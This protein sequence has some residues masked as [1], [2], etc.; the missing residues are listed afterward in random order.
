MAG[1]RV[2]YIID[3]V[4]QDKQLRQQMAKINWEELI[5]SKGKGVSDAF[6]KGTADAANQLKNTFSG[7]NIDW[8]QI[9]GAKDLGRLEQQMAKVL[10][11][12]KNQIKAFAAM[13]DVSGIQRTVEYVSALGS[14]LKGLG[15]NFDAAQ[16]TRGMTS[17]MRVLGPLSGKIDELANE[18]KK[19]EAAFDILFNKTS[20]GMNNMVKSSEKIT[21]VMSKIEASTKKTGGAQA[22]LDKLVKRFGE[23]QNVKLPDLSSFTFSQLETEMEK[24][25]AKW[26]QLESKFAGKKRSAEYLF[27][28]GQLLM[29]EK[30]ISQAYAS[31]SGAS[32]ASAADIQDIEKQIQRIYSVVE[33]EIQKLQNQLSSDTFAQSLAKQLS[34][35]QVKLSLPDTAR[36]ELRSQINTFINELNESGI[37][38]A[39][40]KIDY[41]LTNSDVKSGIAN[42]VDV[43][44]FEQMLQSEID[45]IDTK[46]AELKEKQSQ[47]EEV[48]NL[49]PKNTTAKSKYNMATAQLEELTKQKQANEYSL[50]NIH[51]EGVQRALT[52]SLNDFKAINKVLSSQQ[53]SMLAETIAWRQKMID[54]M[55]FGKGDI[56]F[57]FGIG[58][59]DS[60]AESLLDELNAFFANNVIDINI[61]KEKLRKDIVSAFGEGGVALGGGGVG[62]AA[63]DYQSLVSAIATGLQAALTGD[64]TPVTG[65]QKGDSGVKQTPVVPVKK[66]MYLDP[67]DPYNAYMG[68]AFI[69]IAKYAQG[70]GKPATALSSF[71]DRKGLDPE[72]LKSIADSG[73]I[74]NALDG[75]ATV[76]EKGGA[77]LDDEFKSLVGSVGRNKALSTFSTDLSELLYTL[78]IS[79]K[80]VSQDEISRQSIDVFKDFANKQQLVSGLSNIRNLKP[81]NL[82]SLKSEDIGNWASIAQ[83]IS[84]EALKSGNAVGGE[85][86]KNIVN[87]LNTLKTARENAGNLDD[88]SKQQQLSNAVTQFKSSIEQVYNDLITYITTFRMHAYVKGK[89]PIAVAGGASGRSLSRVLNALGGD[90]S[91][92]EDVTLQQYPNTAALGVMGRRDEQRLMRQSGENTL[93]RPGPDRM[94]I[95]NKDVTVRDFVLKENTSTKWQDP[96]EASQAASRRARAAADMLEDAEKRATSLAN[97]EAELEQQIAAKRQQK[98]TAESEIAKNQKQISR[99]IGEDSR[100]I[101]GAQTRLKNSEA[102]V[103]ST[104]QALTLARNELEKAQMEKEE[105]DKLYAQIQKNAARGTYKQYEDADAQVAKYEAWGKNPLKYRKDMIGEVKTYTDKNGVVHQSLQGGIYDDDYR[106]AMYYK[107]QAEQQVG[108]TE[109]LLAEA[110]HKVTN[111]QKSIEKFG[112]TPE[113]RQSL[114]RAMAD[115][116]ELQNRLVIYKNEVEKNQ[117]IINDI[118]RK[119]KGTDAQDKKDFAADAKRKINGYSDENGDYVP[120][121]LQN[122]LQYRR[123]LGANPET[124]AQSRLEQANVMLETAQTQADK[125]QQAYDTALKKQNELVKSDEYI[126]KAVKVNAL[127]NKNELLSQE[128][129]DLN[130][131]IQKD[132]AAKAQTTEAMQTSAAK[133]RLSATEGLEAS[134]NEL[135]SKQAVLEK[136][137]LDSK[138]KAES[139]DNFV[140]QKMKQRNHQIPKNNIGHTKKEMK[141]IDDYYSYQSRGEYL[142]S[143]VTDSFKSGN[144]VPSN[145]TDSMKQAVKVLTDGRSIL[146]SLSEFS[147]EADVQAEV[148]SRLEKN[149]AGRSKISSLIAEYYNRILNDGQVGATEWLNTQMSTASQK[150]KTLSDADVNKASELKP[151][152]DKL[153][154]GLRQSYKDNVN[155]WMTSLQQKIATLNTEGLSEKDSL[156]ATKE[157]EGL[158]DLI[159]KAV[160]DYNKRYISKFNT[161]IQHEQDNIEGLQKELNA[162]IKK[163]DLVEQARIEEKI[164]NAQEIIS[165][166]EKRKSELALLTPEQ[167]GLMSTRSKY[168]Y[169][170]RLNA[171]TNQKERELR[172]TLSDTQS[173][174]SERSM[175]LK[176]R[177]AEILKALQ[178]PSTSKSST[179]KLQ[180]ELQGINVE[181]AKYQQ[182]SQTLSVHNIFADDVAFVDEYKAKL[183]E[184]IALEQQ[185]DI[186]RSTGAPS[187]DLESRYAEINSKQATLD[188]SVYDKLQAKQRNLL[189]DISTFAKEGKSTSMLEQSL[190]NV[191]TLLAKYELRKRR[192]EQSSISQG[193]ESLFGTSEYV[194]KIYNEKIKETI[195][196]EQELALVR[197]KSKDVTKDQAVKDATSALNAH[198]N[199]AKKAIQRAM[200]DQADIDARGSARVQ[201]LEYL[202]E[203]EQA[204]HDA[205]KKKY[206]L[207]GRI[208]RKEG[209][210]EDVAY[211]D[212]YQNTYLYRQHLNAKK[213]QMIDEYRY[214]DQYAADKDSGMAK[215]EAEMRAYLS[216]T[217]GPEAVERVMYEL[218][219]NPGE[220][221][222]SGLKDAF[223]N[224]LVNGFQDKEGIFNNARQVAEQE[225]RASKEYQDLVAN[226]QSYDQSALDQKMYESR[227]ALSA[228]FDSIDA[229]T[230]Q[231]IQL[232]QSVT[233]QDYAPLKEEMSKVSS[234]VNLAKMQDEFQQALKGFS[235]KNSG[236]LQGMKT[237]LGGIAGRNGASDIEVSQ[238]LSA[239]EGI[240]ATKLKKV[241]EWAPNV[242]SNVFDT[243]DE[244]F[245][246]QARANLIEQERARAEAEK[247][248][249]QKEYNAEETR[250]KSSL[251]KESREI[252]DQ[253]IDDYITTYINKRM[254]SA[255]SDDVFA[256]QVGAK[257]SNITSHFQ[258]LMEKYV[259][260]LM[261]NYAQSLQVGVNMPNSAEI[262][263]EVVDRLN[264]EINILRSKETPIQEDID[265]IEEQRKTAMTKGGIGRN[266]IAD[267][268]ILKQQAMFASKLTAEKEKQRIITEEIAR[269]EQEGGQADKIAELNKSFDASKAISDRMQMLID[270]R[271]GLMELQRQMKVDEKAEKTLTPEQQRLWMTNALEAAKLNLDSEDPTKKKIAEENVARYTD[272]LSKLDAQVA[273]QKPEENGT[274]GILGQLLDVIKGKGVTEGA[275]AVSQTTIERIAADVSQILVALGGHTG[276]GTLKNPDI[277]NKLAK[278]R[279]LEEKYGGKPGQKIGQGNDKILY[280]RKDYNEYKQLKGETKNYNPQQTTTNEDS[281]LVKILTAINSLA[282]DG[283]SSK[284]TSTSSKPKTDVA[285]Q[286]TEAELIRDRALVQDEI[287]R[288]LSAGKAGLYD[289]YVK[290]VEDLNNAVKEANKADDKHKA[291]AIN[292]VKTAADKVTALS[293]NI[294]KDTADWEY[295]SAQGTIVKS[296][297]K[298]K[299]ITQEEMETLAKTQAGVNK[300]QNQYKFLGFDGNTLTYQLTDIEGKVRNVTMEWNAFNKEIAITSDKSTYKLTELAKKVSSLNSKFDEAKNIGYLSGKDKDLQAFYAQLKKIDNL[301]KSGASF[302]EV[303]KARGKAIAL[304][305]VVNTKIN[306]NKKLANGGA[307]GAVN[308]QYD[309]VINTVGSREAFDESELGIVQQYKTAYENLRKTYKS[310]YAEKG[311]L[312][313]KEQEDLRRQILMVQQLGRQTI[314][315]VGEEKE[316]R[317]LVESSGQFK[318]I[319]GEYVQLGG[320]KENLTAEETAVGNLKSTMLDY[321]KNELNMANLE[322][323]KFNNTTQTLTGTIRTSSD[324]VSDIAIKYHE[325]SNALYAYNKQERESLTGIKGAIKG[326]KSKISSLT[327]YLTGITMIYRVWGEFK[328]GVQYIQEIDAALTELKKVTD[329]T[330]ATYDR[331]LKT[332]SKTAGKIGSTIKE[333]VSSTADFARLGYT[334][335]EAATMAEAAQVLMNVSEFTDV[336]VATDSLISSIQAF[337]YTAEESMDVVDILNTIGNNYAIS[338]ADLATSLTK[339][340]GSLVAANGTLEEAVA[341]TATANTI[342]QDADV[343]GTALKTVAMRLRGTDTKTMEDEGLDVDGV[344]ESKSK[345]Q[346]KIKSLSGVDI[347][348]DTGAYKSTYQIL[349]EIADVWEDISDIDQAALLE[350]LA[351]KRAG[352]V[353]SAILQNPETLKD[354]FESANNATGS[355]LKENETYLDSIQGKID[356]FNNAIQTLWSNA[357]NDDVIKFLVNVGTQLVKLID[358]FGFIKTLVIGIGT[359]ITKKYFN[360]NIFGDLTNGTIQNVGQMKKTLSQLQQIRDDAALKMTENPN[361][362]NQKRLNKA[363]SNFDTYE[364]AVSPHIKEYDTLN[365]KLKTAQNNLDKYQNRLNNYQGSNKKTIKQYQDSVNKAQEEVNDLQTQIKNVEN[366][367]HKTGQAGL[368]AGQKFSL[369]FKNAGKAVWQ[370]GKQILSSLATMYVM[371]TAIELFTEIGHKLEELA[372]KLVETP[373]E[374][375][376]KFEE[377]NN[378]L[379]EVSSELSNLRSELK[380]TEERI[381]ELL[382]KS[383]LSFTEQEEL[384]NLRATNA[385]LERK[386]K[387]NKILEQ[388][389]QT[390]VNGAAVNATDK[391]MSNTS[392]DSDI[393]KT[394]KQEQW[395]EVG[396]FIG[397]TGGLI[398]GA[399]IGAALGS[400]APGI[401]NIIGAA[402]GA[403]I[404]GALGKFIGSSV[405]GSAYDSEQSVGEAMD[406]MVAQRLALKKEQEE[407]LA[408]KDT[409]AYNEATEALARY[410]QQMATHITQIQANYNAMDWSTATEDQKK[411][412]IEYADWLDKYAINM[413]TEGAKSSAIERIFNSEESSQALKN[414][415]KQI[416]DKIKS[417]EEFDFYKT[418]DIYVSSE[419][420]KRL[421]QLGI[422]LTD[423]KYYYLD[424]K[425]TEEETEGSTYNVVKSVESLSDCISGLKEAFT[426]FREE[427]LVTAATLVELYDIFGSLGDAWDNYVD[428]MSSGT[429]STKEAKEATLELLEALTNQHLAQGPIKDVKE[430]LTLIA[431]LQ[432][433]GV[434]NAKSYVDALQKSSMISGIGKDIINQEKELAEL[435]QKRRDGEISQTDY[436]NQRANLQKSQEDFIEQYESEYGVTLSYEERLAIEKAITAEK[437]KQAATEAQAKHNE[438]EEAVR[439]KEEAERALKEAQQGT[440]KKVSEVGTKYNR[441]GSV[442]YEYEGQYYTD[443]NARVKYVDSE[444]VKEAQA[445]VDSIYVPVD[446]NVDSAEKAAENAKEIFEETLD[447]LGL[448]LEVE[449]YEATQAVDD[450]QSIYDAL[451]NAKKEYN[452]QG[453]L[454][455]D[456]MQSLLGLEPKY[457]ALL[458]NENGQLQ[459]NEEALLK[460]AE[461]RIIDM[462]IT[463]QKAILEEAITLATDGSR[464]ALLE[465]ISVIEAATDANKDFI[466]T[467]LDV[468]RTKLTARTVDR[469]GTDENGNEITIKADLSNYDVENIMSGVQNQLNASQYTI[470][471]AVKGLPKGGLSSGGSD[472]ESALEKLQKKYERQISNLDNQQEYLENEIERLEA[473]NK[474]VSKSYYEEQIKIEEQKMNLLKQEQAELNKLLA[475]TSKGSDQWWEVSEAIWEVELATQ[476]SVLRTIEFRKSIA[477]LYKTAFD[478]IDDAYGDIDDLYADRRASIEDYMELMELQGKGTPMSAY[479]DL[480]AQDANRKANAIAELNSLRETLARSMAEDD[481]KEGDPE[482]VEMQ[483]AMRDTEAEIRELEISMERTKQEAKEMW[484][485]VFA[486][487]DQAYGNKDNLYSDRQAYIEKYM[488]LLELQ[489]QAIPASGYMDLIEE[490]EAKLANNTAELASLKATLAASIASGYVQYGDP[491]W[492]EMNETIRETEAAILDNKVAIEEYKKSLKEL[493]VEAFELVRDA[494]SNRNDYYTNQQDYIEGYIDYLEAMNMDASSE[495]Y[496]KLI[497][498]EKEKRAN[499]IADLTDARVG[500]AELEAAGY[501]AA[502][503]E[504]VD[505]N[506]RIVDLEKAVQDNDIAMAEWQKT[507]REMDFEKFDQFAER[508][509]SLNE[510]LDNIYKLIEDEDVAFDDGTWTKEGITALSMLYHQIENNKKMIDEYNEELNKLEQQYK[511]GEISEKE[512]TERAEELKD[513]QWELIHTNEDL[514]D[515]IIDINEARV[516]LI[517]E[518]INEEIDAYKELIELKQEELDAERD[519]Y[520]FRK[521]IEKQTKE[522]SELERK[523]ASLSGSDDASDI[524]ERRRLEAQLRDAKDNLGDS[525]YS[526]AKDAQ[527]KALSDELDSYQ[528]SAEDYIETLREQLENTEAMI[529]ETFSSVLLNADTTYQELLVI[530]DTY[531]VTLSEN[532]VKPWYDMGNEAIRVKT[533]IGEALLVL[534]EDDIATFKANATPL[535]TAPF[536]QGGSMAEAFKVTT[537]IQIDEIQDKINTASS[538]FTKDLVYPWKATATPINTFSTNTETALTDAI[539]SAQSKAQGMTDAITSPWDDGADSAT[540]FSYKSEAGLNKALDDALD[541]V[542]DMTDYIT[543]PWKAGVGEINTWSEAVAQALGDAVRQAEEAAKAI[544]TIEGVY[545]IPDHSTTQQPSTSGGGGGIKETKPTAKQIGT[546]GGLTYVT[547]GET[548]TASDGNS[549]TLVGD[550]YYRTS[551]IGYMTEPGS[552]KKS[553]YVV[554][555]AKAYSVG[556]SDPTSRFKLDSTVTGPQA[557]KSYKNPNSYYLQ[558]TDN[559]N[560]YIAWSG[561]GGDA[562]W[563]TIGNSKTGAE[564]VVDALKSTNGWKP[565]RNYSV[566]TRKYA[567]GTLGTTKDEWA[568]T[569]EPWLGDEL[570]LI[571]GANGNLQYMRKG[572]A[573]MPADISANLVEWGKINPDMAALTNGIQGVNLMSNYVS[574]P[575]MNLTF[576]SLVH[577]DHCDEGTLK[578]LEKMVDTKI[579][580]FS[581]QMNYAIKR[582]K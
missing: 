412:M 211:S 414:F 302:A 126:K 78:N 454:S 104:S 103:E 509:N 65:G 339:S 35:I 6:T 134:I 219:R 291:R 184:I 127:N 181:L 149:A 344:V 398:A 74:M 569:D 224:M 53:S 494:F 40:I 24:L 496:D 567:K 58:R 527:S 96:L 253:R 332:A 562:Y 450:I 403:L 375:Q 42:N 157:I 230:N 530:S 367:T 268:D 142:D 580:Q 12:S 466:E 326:F 342:I 256:E 304:G 338:T 387:L 80:T 109:K 241:G 244:G 197:A 355:A 404:F 529:E 202:R 352:S 500:L 215:V 373:E 15:S 389:K 72:R 152:V 437:T 128:V 164:K 39:K 325:A 32:E 151:T 173:K 519:L 391:Y 405:A 368:T 490:E 458:Y 522:I 36:E 143:I 62:G 165:Q 581:K 189:T 426:E 502:D 504:W 574:K 300:G 237:I 156:L 188:Q 203:T 322:H 98:A 559:G 570:V 212:N 420:E 432:S 525:Y 47:Y 262:R 281:I 313:E 252:L 477:D 411:K 539:T 11:G 19:V 125:A 196:L 31:I 376:E 577:V 16:L 310:V 305:D 279:Q 114:D 84:E 503:K 436:E 68:K 120:G 86:Y 121:K 208:K 533:Q 183:G 111:L 207:K 545:N 507:I 417:D 476:E 554:K 63:V 526:H 129:T 57:N 71:F 425:K 130:A 52:S 484:A 547:V 421:E 124:E 77:T 334:M 294:I 112:E 238:L 213:S 289:K 386:I 301:I 392:F 38:P 528:K 568:Y 267:A 272:L 388:S 258:S 248:A 192:I 434:T 70:K 41:S 460:V 105:A 239:L 550:V 73:S 429:S 532:L 439:K 51:S 409:K 431:Q 531:S 87:M 107:T 79:Q 61:N 501:T 141:T 382:S 249:L 510:E 369:G 461:A 520:E 232:I 242:F 401:G 329:E 137:I 327:Y 278:M 487:I 225:Y 493:H 108:E 452:E 472:G 122:A 54:A 544:D 424:W 187:S 46:I 514:K 359:Y 76:I 517:E 443:E 469:I 106:N 8:N 351:G 9:L 378:E 138:A 483:S 153:N 330:E 18:P 17:F 198:K 552:G 582:Y 407:A 479:A 419:T 178:D 29:E 169:G 81:E 97:T 144:F 505:A 123:E 380:N 259:Y 415:D 561:S 457:L 307:L 115:E 177:R 456:T 320:I 557:G 418:F 315:E 319:R 521:N 383:S 390:E 20:L 462:G 195:R 276:A 245:R 349:S 341:L 263:Q 358:N 537:S 498:I 441:S 185:V 555:G 408:D 571:P 576:D 345:L 150:L 146:R 371:S 290:D 324:T 235:V 206:T 101:S 275:E 428:I 186:A 218:T 191:N 323:I 318:N 148:Q 171:E 27:Q 131:R 523:I 311:S 363:Q 560:Y 542:V 463:Q 347:L 316:L 489:G 145:L 286:K 482:W 158:F 214:S 406:D 350:I 491:K 226:R 365:E 575:E 199:N 56:D 30:N 573:V 117:A 194:I 553:Y 22:T 499:N 308:R 298:K 205:Y 447:D 372:D 13:D 14:E 440:T 163:G 269:L 147:S 558:D 180:T 438:Y 516:D 578:D 154:E 402:A 433:L 227:N 250:V 348:T 175:A 497:E 335:E 1:N 395:G 266:E 524:A 486:D 243:T 166:Y 374:A 312:N 174:I 518:G 201:A 459:L 333:V 449:L 468:L 285:T 136:E 83:G 216:K 543:S 563:V 139:I 99:I 273:A 309:K 541:K 579:D 534:N 566:F 284:N 182:Y 464:E 565:G 89:S 26:D 471:L 133:S 75:L 251:A 247:A 448:T 430:Y 357:L 221:N 444:A 481:I 270:N 210:L 229:R 170:T 43:G 346:G 400:F 135:I 260:N 445:K 155:T 446:V 379:A 161:G 474:G 274:R 535:L 48:L 314:A 55:H 328:K 453:Y 413:G 362:I 511:S 303:D 23:L 168:S 7:L 33:R 119:R 296:Y 377:L 93:Y 508:V 277:E 321:A 118:Y 366:Q 467:Q 132:V 222:I 246:K 34:D 396:E 354:A 257:A 37:T 381:D 540:T 399:K 515:S 423:L 353:M 231:A 160:L 485:A 88:E 394:E 92:L 397:K 254:E 293:R 85:Y 488:D 100:K 69:D 179:K 455:V 475:S 255:F 220:A 4:V 200:N 60:A 159:N 236:G 116:K 228:S 67:Q 162:A 45:V 140:S 234:R 113:L 360:G 473:E 25:E 283:I 193:E 21:H 204:Y 82:A 361:K 5:G 546:S 292:R 506:K 44:K 331:F 556:G 90:W 410:D 451:K 10:A 217:I 393:S 549:Y 66:S 223:G 209:L 416:K 564:S 384:E 536:E 59:I 288:K 271:D 280:N 356:L 317:R 435:A 551:D 572:T 299:N 340:S 176:T 3:L 167:E 343:V 233:E 480:I 478:K 2:Q 264:S 282:K 370:F 512:Y 492:V 91:K 513:N 172:G 261:S 422:S 110:P 427:G 50:A 287:V 49:N 28:K 538:E 240:G 306:Q 297:K 495:I 190:G 336:S 64:F 95:L 442:W 385:E 295:K 364:R 465:Y 470:D 102:K 337:K 548:K 265:R 94:D